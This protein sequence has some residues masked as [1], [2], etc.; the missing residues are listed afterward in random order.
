MLIYLVQHGKAKT[1]E[2]DPE[3][4]LS[5]QGKKDVEKAALLLKKLNV[6]VESIMHS[7]KLRAKETAVILAKG[8][9]SNKSIQE[10]PGLLPND[11]IIPIA[12]FINQE[13]NNLMLVGHLPFMDK[14]TSLLITEKEE[15]NI[16]TFQQGSVLCLEKNEALKK[17]SIKWMITPEIANELS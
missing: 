13:N 6:N 10:I 11:N 7:E 8:V 5:N 3:R 15:S 17:Y 16:V 14:L 9:I 4:P 2:E 12:T 1:K